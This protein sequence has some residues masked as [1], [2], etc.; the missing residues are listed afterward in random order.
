MPVLPR[1]YPTWSE[2]TKVRGPGVEAEDTL[3]G[4]T[5]YSYRVLQNLEF[6]KLNHFQIWHCTKT[7]IVYGLVWSVLLTTYTVDIASV[8][9]FKTLYRH[10]Q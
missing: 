1:F 4:C 9:F 10:P 8:G 6:E 5:I 2:N 7:Y 3:Y